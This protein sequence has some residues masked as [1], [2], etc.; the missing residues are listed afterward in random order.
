MCGRYA[1][2]RSEVDLMGGYE[3]DEVVGPGPEPSWNIAPTQD[4]RVVVERLLPERPEP[5]RQLRTMRW[6]LV[7]SW[8]RDPKVGSRMINARV[9]TVLEKPS[10]RSAVTRR[11]L[12]VPAD[13]YFEWEPAPEAPG[14]KVP[15]FL[16]RPDAGLAFAGLYELWRVPDK[17]ADDPQRWLF[18]Y[19]ILTTAAPDALGHIHD[20]SPVVVPDE[21]LDAW[22][23]PRLTDADG[24]RGLLAAMP[25]PQLVPHAVGR[26]VNNVVNNGP[27]L[28][29]PAPEA[30]APGMPAQQALPL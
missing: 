22:L 17:A 6:G 9:E 25:E 12:V 28:V 18:T 24:V 26:E 1:S 23:D 27:H 2:A 5:T 29:A 11:R 3:V 16:Q 8:A 14:G 10:F 7:P 15:T 13:G 21:L 4:A 30:P 19:T 20:R